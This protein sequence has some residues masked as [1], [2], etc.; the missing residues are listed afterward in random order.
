MSQ[1]N[2][3]VGD[4]RFLAGEDLTGKEGRLV[5]ILA[6]GN[7]G[8][9]RLPT[10]ATDSAAFVLLEGG[11]AGQW[12]ALRPLEPARNVRVPLKGACL[13]GQ[14]LVLADTGVVEDRGKVRVLPN[15]VGTHR[16]RGIAE[17]VGEDGQLI[18]M[19]P[20]LADHTITP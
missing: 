8:K 4:V 1:S 9:V 20:Y 7:V 16:G 6:D 10:Y 13:P 3:R 2:T 17:E 18:L 5:R 12:V 15:E 11:A 14:V 19:R